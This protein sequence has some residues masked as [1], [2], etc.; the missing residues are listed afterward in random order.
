MPQY[1][2]TYAQEHTQV[3]TAPD[4]TEAARRAWSMAGNVKG[5]RVMSVERV[6]VPPPPPVPP[7][8]AK[9]KDKPPF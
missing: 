5:R 9:L 6:N 1:I 4:I 3:L 2:V 8:P 7:A